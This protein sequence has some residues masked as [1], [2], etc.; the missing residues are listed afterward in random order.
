MQTLA[1]DDTD[2][3]MRQFRCHQVLSRLVHGIECFV[4]TQGKQ[5]AFASAPA[6][7]R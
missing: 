2:D 1:G 6:H 4:S 5:T 3:L 7:W